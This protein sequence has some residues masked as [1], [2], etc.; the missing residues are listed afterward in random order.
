[1]RLSELMGKEMVNIATGARLGVLG[2]ADLLV[3]E[4]S[5]LI[6]SLILPQRGLMGWWKEGREMAIPWS[7]VRR[8]GMEIVIIDLEDSYQRVR[9]VSG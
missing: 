8:I 6:H 4:G 5:G 3:D 2:D 7:A 1:M 9:E